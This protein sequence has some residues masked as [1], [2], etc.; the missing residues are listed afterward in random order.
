MLILRF[1][2]ENSPRIIAASGTDPAVL[3]TG[4]QVLV[5]QFYPIYTQ[6]LLNC[7]TLP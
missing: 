3:K 1:V 2:C 5:C 4:S 7:R 6:I